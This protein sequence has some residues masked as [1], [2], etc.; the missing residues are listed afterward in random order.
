LPH[1]F[2][3]VVMIGASQQLFRFRIIIT[4]HNRYREFLSL[5][6]PECR[7]EKFDS[8]Y[9]MSIFRSATPRHKWREFPANAGSFRINHVHPFHWTSFSS[10]S[11]LN[12]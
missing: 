12:Y 4:L 1:E 6:K 8:D 3:A 2:N 10:S 9:V 5:R 7:E 11:C